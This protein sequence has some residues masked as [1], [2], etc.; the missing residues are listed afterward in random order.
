MRAKIRDCEDFRAEVTQLIETDEPMTVQKLAA[1]L[2]EESRQHLD[3][4]QPC[5]AFASALVESV[6]LQP[7]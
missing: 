5:F 7:A 2:T 6:Q 3:Y 1:S 4:C